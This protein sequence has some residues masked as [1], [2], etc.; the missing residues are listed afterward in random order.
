VFLLAA[1]TYLVN[2]NDT[3]A[4]TE[5]LVLG[6]DDYA[7]NPGKVIDERLE[8]LVK[9]GEGFLPEKSALIMKIDAIRPDMEMLGISGLMEK[10]IAVTDLYN[11]AARWRKAPERRA[12]IQLF[13]NLAGKYE[14]RCLSYNT[15]M[16]LHGF[17]NWVKA[18]EEL[19]QSPSL[20]KDAVKV[21]TYFKAKG[22]EW[23]AVIL[24][25]LHSELKVKWY[26]TVALSPNDG[27]D[28]YNPLAGRE[29]I[30]IHCPFGYF[31]RN[32][33]YEY[34]NPPDHVMAQI[35]ASDFYIR[36][37]EKETE[38]RIRIM[39]V[40]ITRARDYLIIPELIDLKE[41]SWWNNTVGCVLPDFFKA[42]NNY[43]IPGEP[44]IHVCVES[45][46]PSEDITVTNDTEC[47]FSDASG[48]KKHGPFRMTPSDFI[49]EH[50]KDAQEA[51]IE[52]RADL[53][54]GRL[55][56]NLN[57]IDLGNALHS[58]LAVWAGATE[59]GKRLETIT[60]VLKGY[61]LGDTVTPGAVDHICSQFFGWIQEN[62]PLC[63]LYR[64]FPLSE[65]RDGQ[66]LHG[67]ADLLIECE[68]TL[69]LVDF[70]SYQ[71]VDLSEHARKYAGQLI[72]YKSMI[73]SA[74]PQRKEVTATLIYYPV[75]GKIVEF[76]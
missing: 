4:I 10:L 64:E 75:T 41:K 44:G 45:L 31:W 12:N 42:T 53:N 11:L 13:L 28:I 68:G 51:I 35:Q 57:E 62:F 21:M 5:L 19:T 29:I 52:L 40:A 7:G 22:L 38:E 54:T 18:Q 48:K 20:A 37:R 61:E 63:I 58:I 30:H 50:G 16:N 46:R 32:N 69:T 26:G 59:K 65:Y 66:L 6:E 15:A 9:N 17:V 76:K 33:K 72:A 8:W 55:C 49:D 74:H 43:S 3:L 2:E 70:K 1:C 67:Y 25:G 56:N 27:F 34:K 47:F 73:K 39:Y 24:S 23:P 14:Q 71:G 36:A 60:N